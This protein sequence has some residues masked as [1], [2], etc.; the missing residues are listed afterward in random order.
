MP[1]QDQGKLTSCCIIEKAAAELCSYR[2][3]PA[4][5]S[6]IQEPGIKHKQ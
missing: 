4:A 3:L 1:A 6:E 2:S 5:P